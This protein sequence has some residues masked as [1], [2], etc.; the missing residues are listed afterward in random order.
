MINT[1]LH[2]WNMNIK[3]L[4]TS[5]QLLKFEIILYNFRHV[6]ICLLEGGQYYFQMGMSWIMM[7]NSLEDL[8]KLPTILRFLDDHVILD[9]YHSILI[10]FIF[11]ITIPRAIFLFPLFHIGAML[12]KFL[13]HILLLNSRLLSFLPWI[14][15]IWN[16]LVFISLGKWVRLYSLRIKYTSVSFGYLFYFA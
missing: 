8:V 16:S 15:M 7:N 5:S 14:A 9:C 6:L 13:F 3:S 4:H 12:S 1:R 2:L 10:A 11:R